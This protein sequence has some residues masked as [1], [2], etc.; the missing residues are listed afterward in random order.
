MVV[1]IIKSSLSNSLA[2]CSE[3]PAV[4]SIMT[5]ECSEGARCF[6]ALL[7]SS[8]LFQC[9][10]ETKQRWLWA[11]NKQSH[12]QTMQCRSSHVK[13]QII[14]NAKEEENNLTWSKKPYITQ[15]CMFVSVM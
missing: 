15:A 7:I 3:S 9:Y 5:Q 14:I 1:H 10:L 13:E 4:V 8:F 11:R 6:L 2:K 12:S